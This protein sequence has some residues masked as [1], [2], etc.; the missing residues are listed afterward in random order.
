MSISTLTRISASLRAA[1]NAAIRAGHITVNAAS[2]ASS[3]AAMGRRTCVSGG[4]WHS[5]T[6]LRRRQHGRLLCVTSSLAFPAF[7]ALVVERVSFHDFVS[8]RE[9]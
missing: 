9:Q 7:T 6:V 1:L 5:G 4:S 2:R 3:S 8:Q